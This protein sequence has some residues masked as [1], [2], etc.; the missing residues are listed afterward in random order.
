MANDDDVL[1]VG[2]GHNALVCAL[3]LAK[4]G[5]R[6]RVLEAKEVL[7]G[8]T[9]T[10]KPFPKAPDLQQSTGAYLLGLMPPELM[11]ELELEVPLLRRDPHYFLPTTGEGYLLFGSDRAETKRQFTSFFSAAD[12]EADERLQAELAQ[13]REDVEMVEGVYDPLD[14]SPS[15]HHAP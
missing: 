12:W 1:V 10:E 9:R 3:K 7:G 8:A 15:I 13:L 5:R 14:D 4:A 11:A 6:V 2:A